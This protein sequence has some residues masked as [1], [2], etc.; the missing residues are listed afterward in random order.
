[1]ARRESNPRGYAL[2]IEHEPGE[3]GRG[4]N[5]RLSLQRAGS[6]DS[7]CQ[8]KPSTALYVAYSHIQ[9]AE[10][11]KHSRFEPFQPLFGNLNEVVGLAVRELVG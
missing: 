2:P 1:M 3:S 5:P 11:R 10:L 6:V 4:S 9:V 8:F 7:T